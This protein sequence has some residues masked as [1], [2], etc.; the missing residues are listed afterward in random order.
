M[1]NI[2]NYWKQTKIKYLLVDTDTIWVRSATMKR[3][4]TV[5]WEN[6]KILKNF[7]IKLRFVGETFAA[8]WD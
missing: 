2:T 7:L 1:D 3:L 5:Q 4:Q 8:T 6:V